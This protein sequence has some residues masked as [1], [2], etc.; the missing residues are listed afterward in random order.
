MKLNKSIFKKILN[1]IKVFFLN[2]K[3]NKKYFF[4]I[5]N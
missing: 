3:L 5:L 4:K 1:Y 2:I